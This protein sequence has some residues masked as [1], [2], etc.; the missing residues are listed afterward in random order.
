MFREKIMDLEKKIKSRLPQEFKSETFSSNLWQGKNLD[1]K[2]TMRLSVKCFDEFPNIQI[3]D[4]DGENADISALAPRT[5][6]TF[7]IA[8]D[9]I[10]STSDKVG[11]NW[12]I[13]QV[14]IS[15]NE[16]PKKKKTFIVR[17]ESDDLEY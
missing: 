3:F 16:T 7:I 15:E 8:L 5:I 12:N 9:S 6:G 1:F 2:P 17:D 13:E 11:I 10:W 4:K 14:Q